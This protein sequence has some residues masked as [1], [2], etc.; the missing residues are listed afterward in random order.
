ML[1]SLV[2]FETVRTTITVPTDLINRSQ[3]FIKNGA[4]PSRNALIVSALEHFLLL[5][6]RQEIDRQ[7]DMLAEDTAY[8]ALNEQVVVDFAD[9]DWDALRVGERQ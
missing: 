4:I 2:Q 3:H 6:E 9:S 1:N 7:F 5:L 8:Q